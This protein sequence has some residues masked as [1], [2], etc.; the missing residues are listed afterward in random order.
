ML[1]LSKTEQLL[2]IAAAAA[3]CMQAASLPE[4]SRYGVSPLT[5]AIVLGILLGNAAAPLMPRLAEGIAFS[6]GRLLRLGIVFYGLRITWAQ[7]AAAGW[8][9]LFADVGAAVCPKVA[10]VAVITKMIRVLLLAPFLLA[11]PW[12]MRRFGAQGSEPSET[13]GRVPLPWFALG[14]IGM[15]ALN[16][17]LP[18]PAAIRPLLLAAVLALWLALGGAALAFLAVRLFG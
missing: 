3:L 16:S 14:F 10:D 6:K 9:A 11:L 2:P 18:P 4:L 5:L 7:L 15:V 12:L 8:A 13:A 1:S 17:V